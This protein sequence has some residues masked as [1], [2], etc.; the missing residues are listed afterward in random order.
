MDTFWIR[1]LFILKKILPIEL[2]KYIFTEKIESAKQI[3]EITSVCYFTTF[4]VYFN[5]F[6][7]YR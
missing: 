3:K 7:Q 1:F 2:V 5:Y 6:Y 4:S